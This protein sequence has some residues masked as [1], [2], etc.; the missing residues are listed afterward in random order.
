MT[1]GFTVELQSD[2]LNPSP[3]NEKK[4]KPPID[5]SNQ[6]KQ[7]RVSLLQR[8]LF[9]KAS[10]RKFT[11]DHGLRQVQNHLTRGQSPTDSQK[12]KK[13]KKKITPPQKR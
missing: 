5:Y 3:D 7:P 11:L 8:K 1:A 4:R 13:M 9:A 2:H 12:Y 10:L 6:K